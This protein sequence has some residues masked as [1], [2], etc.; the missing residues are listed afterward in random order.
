MIL[1]RVILRRLPLRLVSLRM[2]D[3]LLLVVP[4]SNCISRCLHPFS[5]VLSLGTAVYTHWLQDAIVVLVSLISAVP[6]V[7][8]LLDIAAAVLWEELL[9][10]VV[11]IEKVLKV[12]LAGVISADVEVVPLEHAIE[13]GLEDT[14][15]ASECPVNK[16]G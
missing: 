6:G 3:L 13:H 2:P 12:V 16:Q 5:S 9:L 15:N 4:G 1:G 10:L 14:E 8:D 11:S 7:V